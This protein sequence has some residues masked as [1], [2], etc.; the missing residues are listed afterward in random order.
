MNLVQIVPSLP[1]RVDGIGD[2]ALQLARQ[3]RRNHGITTR[4]LIADTSW[5]GAPQL[6][7]FEVQRLD[8]QTPKALV[9]SLGTACGQDERTS[10]LLVHF[11]PYGYEKRGVPFW[12]VRGMEAFLKERSTK[13]NLCLHELERTDAPIWSSGYWVPRL[14]IE[15][16]KRMTRL[17][18][19]RFTN[20]EFHRHKLESWGTGRE[21]L[22][23]NFSTLAEPETYPDAGRRPD[24]IIFGRP[25]VRE[26]VYGTCRDVLA[27][28]CSRF[29]VERIIDIGSP[30]A[31]ESLISLGGASI[32]R[33]GR[34]PEAEVSQWMATS[35]FSFMHYPVQHLTK[36]S[37]LAAAC[38][39]GTIS[40][41]HDP[42]STEVSCPGLETGLDFLP[43]RKSVSE[44]AGFSIPELS[45][46]VF[47]NYGKRASWTAA[48]QVSRWMQHP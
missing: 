27:E 6:E 4:F 15:I 39:H 14:Q 40:F 20:T 45:R 28:V 41:V 8:E 19:L 5:S 47:D 29:G 43:L 36:S 10:S 44:L 9:T 11:S 16:L 3:L 7:G 23:L 26:P 24:L 1:P 30:L 12:F 25:A 21:H 13:L 42:S 33:C 32:V 38:A 48:A 18:A 35:A 31:D 46:A 2:Y 34:L 17:A 37:V 22:L